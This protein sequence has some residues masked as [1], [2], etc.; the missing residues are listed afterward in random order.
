[1]NP[2][3]LKAAGAVPVNFTHAELYDAL[4]KG[5][6]DGSVTDY[7]LMFRF[8]EVEV[9]PYVI[10][11]FIGANSDLSTLIKKDVY[12]KLSPDVQKVLMDLR[13]EYPAK[14]NEFFKKQFMEVSI[15]GLKAAGVKIVD[16]P[17][18][19][20]EALMNHPDVKALSEGWVDWILA[21]KPE[22]TKARAQEIQQ[23]YLKLLDDYAKQYPD[24]LEP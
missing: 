9:T 8:K 10:R 7:D 16:L 14:F 11:L 15:P 3:I 22:L 19:D 23:T 20:L 2:V 1:M 12:D 18:A 13:A 5:E 24:R 4:V 6:V 17:P 21:K